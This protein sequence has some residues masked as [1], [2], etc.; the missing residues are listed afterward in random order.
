[1]GRSKMLASRLR[2]ERGENIDRE[3]LI[4]DLF[5]GE[6]TDPVRIVVFNTAEG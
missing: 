5:S 2:I 1:M 4:R 6:Y 3:T